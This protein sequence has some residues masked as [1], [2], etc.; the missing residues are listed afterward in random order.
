M[1]R[2]ITDAI[3]REAQAFRIWSYATARE[4]DANVADI[5]AALKL[6]V[7]AVRNTCRSRGWSR[8][9]RSESY[10]RSTIPTSPAELRDLIEE[11]A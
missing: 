6:N 8:R 11:F 5:A 2:H 10:D 7:I 4:W 1:A 3:R 9:L